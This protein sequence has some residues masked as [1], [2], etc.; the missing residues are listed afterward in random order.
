MV[1]GIGGIWYKEHQDAKRQESTETSADESNIITWQGKKWRYNKNISNY[2]MIGVDKKEPVETQVG[3]TEA[4]QA[5]AI[6]LLS[7]NRKTEKVT[8]ISIPRDTMTE[9]ESYDVQGKSLGKSVDHISLSYGYGDGGQRSCK[10]TQTAVSNLMYGLPIQGYLSLNMDGIPVLTST[11]GGVTV[12]VPDDSLEASYPEFA[13]GAKVTLTAEN[14]ETFVRARDVNVS[15][16]A[17][18]RMVRQ[19]VYLDAFSQKARECYEHNTAFAASLYSA[20]EPYT[21]TNV[22]EDRLLSLFET[23]AKDEDYTKWTIPGEG[24]QG[25]SY[26]EYHVDDNALYEKIMETFYQEVE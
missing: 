15:Q 20:L 2:L 16:S 23:V 18:N 7:V 12:T 14:S 1:L 10:L 5:D 25:A 4:G 21:V 19:Q 3:S 6:F 8:L 22:S 13:E 17:I 9:V 11:V 24:T 26:D